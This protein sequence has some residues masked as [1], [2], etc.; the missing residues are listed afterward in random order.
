M[1]A[2]ALAALAQTPA[3]APDTVRLA[4]TVELTEAASRSAA[5]FGRLSGLAVDSL[6]NLYI[7]DLSQNQIWVFDSAGRSKGTIGRKGYG[8]GE[9]QSPSG[10]GFDGRGRLYARDLYRITRFIW[11]SRRKLVAQYDTAFNGPLYPNWFGGRATRF[12]HRG[13]L[14][15]PRSF[16]GGRELPPRHF[17]YRYSGTGQMHD[18]VAVPRYPNET[19]GAVL[20]RTSPGGGRMLQGLDHV[21][22]AAIPV[23]D[24]TPRGTVISGSGREYLLEE[25]DPAGRVVRRFTRLVPADRIEARERRD[26][27]I[28]LRRRLDS[29]PVAI[30]RVEGLP[31]DVAAVRLPD[32]YPAYQAVVAANDGSI[33]VRRWPVAGRKVTIF[34]VFDASGR[35]THVVVLPRVILNEPTP[36]ILRGGVL[37]AVEDPE[38]GAIGVLRFGGARP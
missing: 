32:V 38:T 33:W 4:V 6:G 28:A 1:L 27:T 37:A 25:T 23:W 2:L 19:P 10:I 13:L 18:S 29:V 15:Y 12:D 26:S 36:V 5:E 21:P 7:A 11:D 8:P 22:F 24:A 17:F 9:F 35:F 30:G 31:D 14:Y 3:R 20:V 34:D 16:L